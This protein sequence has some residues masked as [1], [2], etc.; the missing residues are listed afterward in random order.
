MPSHKPSPRM[1][2]TAAIFGGMLMLTSISP[3]LPAAPARRPNVLLIITDQQRADM[4]SCAGNRYVKTPAVDSLA[5]SGVR[6]GMAYCANP[7]C[8][9]SRFSMMTGVMPSRIGMDR[10][11]NIPASPAGDR[12]LECALGRVFRAAGYQT[13][14]GGKTHLPMR[15][16]RAYGFDDL[17]RNE[18]EGLAETCTRFLARPHD[19]P[20]LLVASF[21]NPHDI[22]YMAINAAARGM[23]GPPA[24]R[25]GAAEAEALSEAMQWPPG[26][27]R[28]EFFSR[29]CPP[30]PANHEIP[31]DEPPAVRQGDWRSFRQYV[32]KHWTADDWRLHRWT[33][34]RLVERA[35]R[36]IG[37][38]LAA[39][40]SA[41]LEDKTLVVFTS[42]HGDMD[43]SHKLEH[44]SMPYEEAM[45]VPLVVS[46]K[47]VT[48]AGR[49]DTR[50]LVSTGLDLIPTLCDFAGVPIPKSL[51]G[52]SVKPL[53][54]GKDAPRPWRDDLVIEN[55]SSIILRG[56]RFKYAAYDRGQ[57][58]ELLLDL[59][60]DPGEMRNLATDPK[61]RDVLV[62]QRARLQEWYRQ[63]GETLDA[64]F[65]VTGVDR[66]LS[67][68][69]RRGGSSD[70]NT[71]DRRENGTVPLASRRAP[72]K[73]NVVF[74]FADQWRA[75]A[76][77]CA[78]DP[79]AK[80]PHLDRLAAQG[81]MLTTAVSTC[82]VCSPYRA[83]LMTGRYPTTHG[84]FVND[85][86]LNQEAVSL[87]QAFKQ[88]G[89]QTAY[90][91][92]W[93]LD[94]DG[95]SNF[96]PTDRRQGFDFWRVCE[97]THDYNHSLYFGDDPERHFWKGYDALA[98][99]EEARTYIRAHR[100]GPFLLMLSWGPPHNPYETAPERFRRMFKAE[101]LQL[102]PNV[103]PEVQAATRR[104]LAGYYAHCAALDECV[105]KIMETLNECHLADDTILVFTADHGDM[106]GSHGQV[107]KQRPWDESILVPFLLRWPNG[108]KRAAHRLSSPF[109]T[110]D[111]MPTLLGLCGIPSPATVEGA[112]RSAWL[113][114][115]EPDA[116]R[117]VLIECV[118]PF[119]EW[120]RRQGGR[121][122]R[123]L[124]T[125]QYTF[126]R[127]RTGPWLLFDNQADPYQEHNLVGNPR[128]AAL[129]K[130]LDSMLSQ[131]LK[132]RHDDFAPG[133]VYLD[134]WGY[135]TDASGTVRYQP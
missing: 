106:L 122:Y 58:R 107:R 130:Q 6:F 88:A 92:K 28:E 96:I 124:R 123:G 18:R 59:Q 133:R 37:Q 8:S 47:G 42:D 128:Y 66:G 74:V 16:I 100:Q 102:R 11:M 111:I 4:L 119:G 76:L 25:A 78:G 84:V 112:D 38:V 91:G 56:R 63:H 49:L 55:E 67:R 73:P 20:F 80:T 132:R 61:Y 29:L 23:G 94:G 105:G 3:A 10:N 12:L 87:A 34:A 57:P 113:R 82:P 103:P 15:D 32:E 114:E 120:T 27:S 35:D 127:S 31:E 44:K 14:Y 62:E 50:H 1:F 52:R 77:G 86:R 72:R 17:T 46:W 68:F 64:K 97:C 135:K 108:L 93:H 75:Q 2:F 110:P 48:P 126:V 101:S 69:S 90:I 60:N 85:V 9:P 99:T 65:V 19:R 81:V 45:H 21:I 24:V 5:A 125:R 134:K 7:V 98:Q 121:E 109:C 54:I 26:V 79:N 131:E 30:L 95:R 83:S 104:D 70:T 116:D 89:Y 53:A 129:Q 71:V 43:A 117:P 36:Q 33:Y 13:V 22:C 39:L 51:K 115:Q 118:T 41:G 40:R